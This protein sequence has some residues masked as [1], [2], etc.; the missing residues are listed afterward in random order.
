MLTMST[1][2]GGG[3]SDGG[4]IVHISLGSS[5]NY[6]TSHLLN[7][8]GLAATA[9]TSPAPSSDYYSDGGDGR[10]WESLCD[11]SV[12]HCIASSKTAS[13]TNRSYYVPQTLIVDGRDS[14]GRPWDC[15]GSSDIGV[16]SL[17]HS[18][19]MHTAGAAASAWDGAISIFNP[20]F[21]G[22]NIGYTTNE[23]GDVDSNDQTHR[24]QRQRLGQRH[25]DNSTTAD[26]LHKFHEAA[27]NMGLS[28][29]HSR[30]RAAAPYSSSSIASPYN[31]SSSYNANNDDGDNR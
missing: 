22:E 6:I 23:N 3:G 10:K 7:L 4:E 2:N 20:S 29:Q 12:T 25:D 14:F 8:Q 27:S 11:P 16:S 1:S 26:P 24:Q 13:S 9:S 31:I 17:K 21:S 28:S 19:Q 18:T 30:F 15:G 5:A